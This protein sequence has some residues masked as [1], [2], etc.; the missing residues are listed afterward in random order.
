MS[1]AMH[2][3]KQP[4]E[5]SQGSIMIT[6]D[7]TNDR[8]HPK[9]LR[10]GQR[11]EMGG[12]SGR[13]EIDGGGG[14]EPAAVVISIGQGERR[15]GPKRG[16]HPIDNTIQDFRGPSSVTPSREAVSLVVPR[17]VSGPDAKGKAE[18]NTGGMLHRVDP[19]Q[20]PSLPAKVYELSARILDRLFRIEAR[21][22]PHDPNRQLQGGI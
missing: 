5:V 3:R 2:K 4:F 22:G 9:R 19:V 18:H 21:T 11:V 16:V 15:A 12:N 6:V 13:F 8:E 20:E 14:A 1:E 17:Y 10:F 7:R